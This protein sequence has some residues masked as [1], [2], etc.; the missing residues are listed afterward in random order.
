MAGD[1]GDSQHNA[2]GYP[3]RSDYGPAG[4]AKRVAQT[5]SVIGREFGAATLAEIYENPGS[6]DESITDL[7]RRELIRGK[8]RIPHLQYMYKHILTQKAAYA[9]L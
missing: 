1:Q 2:A 5:A 4:P 7:Q 9:S 3:G 8:S 6:L